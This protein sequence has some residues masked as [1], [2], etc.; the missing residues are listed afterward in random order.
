MENDP[1]ACAPTRALIDSESAQPED[2]SA[3]RGS[4]A[5]EMLQLT[6]R[7]GSL[8]A[9]DGLTLTVPAASIFGL[10]GP[11]GAGKS[12]TIKMLATLLPASS[13][14]ARVAGF[15]VTRQPYGVRRHIGYVPQVLSADGALTGYENLLLLAKLYGVPGSERNDRIRDALEFTGL[16]D[17]RDKLVREYSGGMI[18]RLEIAQSMLH[19]P[20]V[21]F[22]DEPTVG[23]DPVARRTVWDHIRALR[24]QFGTTILMTTHYMEEADELCD[25]VAIMHR[26]RV[27]A[28]GSPA[29]LKAAAGPAAN[30]EDV[31]VHFAG[32]ALDS[33]GSYKDFEASLQGLGLLVL[34]AIV[35]IYL[36]LG[37]LYESFI[38]P[39]TILSGLPSAGVGALLTLLL[40]RMEL[41]L[42][43]FVGI[44]MLIGIVKKNAI[45]MI[46]FAQ[47]AEGRGKSP[48]EAIYEGCLLR[49]RPIMMTT[50]SALM[51]TLPIAI[52]FGAG[53]E[54][55]R[56]LGLAVVG[57]L[58][59]SQL[60]TLYITP[61]TYTY[62]ESLNAWLSARSRPRRATTESPFPV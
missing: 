54:S 57:G 5:I 19:R 22:L 21:L 16:T 34:A 42:Y 25:L 23:L 49:F 11:N 30:L 35:V 41:N 51:G 59:L 2:C 9:V 7:F 32:H 62:L 1:G 8:I 44:I 12:T 20:A 56:P 55:R 39:L 58:I 50:M 40:F 37:I 24:C 61:V 43:G 6:R 13:G 48:A 60:L 29:E 28:V 3:S 53:A 18:R 33:G 38:H 46:D 36:V 31:F 52:G 10:L 4:A 15:D 47:Q 26:G 45:M 27:A 14:V 17:A